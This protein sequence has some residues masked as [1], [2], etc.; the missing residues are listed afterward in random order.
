[1]KPYFTKTPNWIK[2]LYP[3]QVWS[4]PNSNKE[5]YLTFDD[6]PTPE[7]TD[8]VLNTLQKYSAKATFFCIGNNIEKYPSIFENIIKADHSIGNHT[9]NHEKGWKTKDEEYVNSVSK[10]EKIIE[11]TKKNSE[12]KTLNSELLFR[13][14]YGKMKKSQIKLLRKN[15]YKIIMWS[16]LSADF[17]TTINA[18]KCLNNVI[19][20]AKSGDIIVFHD[21]IKA[22]EKLKM[23]LPKVLEYYSEKG[24]K[25]DRIN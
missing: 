21:S 10:T 12:L 9:Y 17:D 20:N 22:F 11:K 6:G 7:I 15:N 14:P 5:I 24:Y 23:V 16:V 3:N 13:P 4:L 2:T 8:W 19:K 1:M 25:F 18:E